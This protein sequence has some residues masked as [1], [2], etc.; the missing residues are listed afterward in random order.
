MT[1]DGGR[2]RQ[3]VEALNLSGCTWSPDGKQI[4]FA[5]GNPGVEGVNIHIID[6]NGNN[7]R[8]LTR[9]GPNALARHPAWSPDGETIAYFFVVL[10]ILEAGQAIPINEAFRNNVISVVNAD[11]KDNAQ[12]LEA[13]RRVSS[14]PVW[15]P[16]G[17]FPVSPQPQL[18]PTQ[19]GQLKK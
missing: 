10:P 6:S 19:W 16:E 5:A 3:L 9:V 2:S 12:P 14:S 13:T 7:R 8:T 4:A 11:G 18:L 17:F 1:A 15:V